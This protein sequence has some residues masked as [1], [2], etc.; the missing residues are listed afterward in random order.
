MINKSLN[1]EI[2]ETCLLY[3]DV[4]VSYSKLANNCSIGD[5][6]RVDYSNLAG[7]VRVNR[8]NHIYKTSLGSHTYTGQNT[9]IMDAKIGNFCSIAWN[10]TIGAAEHDFNKITTHAFLYN[11]YDHIRP[12]EKDEAYDRFEKEIVIGNDV[13]IGANAIILRGVNVSDGAVIGAGAVVTKDVP[14]YAIV[15]GNPAKVI[16]YRFSDEMIKE[17]LEL[18][19]WNFTDDKIQELYPYFDK[20]LTIESLKELKEKVMS[21]E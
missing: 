10:I 12:E 6:S 1:S 18:K 8:M 5:F 9:V 20:D 4:R 2:D 13:W 17:L 21:V 11:Q 3:K 19:W 16:K 14:P 7:H 15:A